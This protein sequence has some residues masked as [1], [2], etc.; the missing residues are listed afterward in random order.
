MGTH[1]PQKVEAKNIIN[2][3][4]NNMNEYYV[5]TK[6]HILYFDSIL[7]LSIPGEEERGGER[8][9]PTLNNHESDY[10]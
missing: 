9:V 6:I 4:I 3:S 1:N 5:C 7:V 8:E 10:I 2:I